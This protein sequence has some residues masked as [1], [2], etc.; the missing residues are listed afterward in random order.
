MSETCCT[1]PASKDIVRIVVVNIDNQNDFVKKDGRLSVPGAVAAANRAARFIDVNRE[2]I[3]TII[4]SFDK[5]HL[6]HIF[7]AY[8]W[9]D[10]KGNHP[11][12]F[13][14]I[15]YS[16]VQNGVWIP[17]IL[18][19]WS[20]N[21]VKALGSFTIWPI[22]CTAGTLGSAMVDVLAVALSI[23]SIVRKANPKSIIKG[24]NS[25]TEHYGIFKAEVVDPEDCKTKLNT[26]R[27]Q[28]IAG[29]D[30]S[31]WFG[32]EKNHCVRRS[33]EQYIGWC[34]KNQSEAIGRM[35]YVEDC[36]SLLQLGPEYEKDAENSV[37]SMVQKGMV[38]VR[39]TDPIEE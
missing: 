34:E 17:I 38:V 16:D 20:E 12:D 3:T 11:Q 15:T 36:T 33:L 6:L 8:W 9:Q 10:A 21:Y 27:L 31:Y 19:E 30:L 39:S 13:T 4:S 25:R 35:R 14:E 2:R 32:Q 18:K 23:H 24:Q 28:Q 37:K 5:H 29:Y 26:Y 7:Y 1:I 22:H